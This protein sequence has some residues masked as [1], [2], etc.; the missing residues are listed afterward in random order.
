MNTD[1]GAVMVWT[2]VDGA[3]AARKLARGAVENR[4]AACVQRLPVQ[5]VYRWKGAVE[6]SSETL[7]V[8][9]TSV[10]RAGKLSA[11]IRKNHPYELPEIVVLPIAE[12]L[13]AYLDWIRNET[14]PLSID[15]SPQN[16]LA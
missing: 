12:G 8:M 9:K 7:L 11:W 2:A 16:S 15:A 13:P 4:L 3:Q 14:I 6:E 10:T 5:S 1:T